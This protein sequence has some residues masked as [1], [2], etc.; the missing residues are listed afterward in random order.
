[1]RDFTVSASC[2]HRSRNG[3]DSGPLRTAALVALGHYEWFNGSGYP[4][5]L[6]G[7]HI[8]LAARIAAVADRLD[9]LRVEA[10]AVSWDQ[11][12]AT[13]AEENPRASIPSSST[14]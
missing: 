6:S 11:T 7:D 4:T 12:W 3:H 1:V 5:G 8:P 10:P 14:R 9:M 13:L 2:C